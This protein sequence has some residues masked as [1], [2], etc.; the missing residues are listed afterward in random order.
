MLLVWLNNPRGLLSIKSY[1]AGNSF[2]SFTEVQLEFEARKES[3]V[4]RATKTNRIQA[5]ARKVQPLEPL[6]GE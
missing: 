1:L 3:F 6:F 2:R 5:G 4:A